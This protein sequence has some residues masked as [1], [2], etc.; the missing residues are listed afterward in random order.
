MKTTDKWIC[1]FCW[2]N[3]YKTVYESRN[4]WSTILRMHKR[5]G[6]SSPVYLCLLAM[7]DII[8]ISRLFITLSLFS[9]FWL[10]M[11]GCGIGNGQSYNIGKGKYNKLPLIYTTQSYFTIYI[12]H[13]AFF[14]LSLL[15]FDSWLVTLSDL[16]WHLI[17]L[18][19]C[20]S[21]SP[22]DLNANLVSILPIYFL[23]LISGWLQ[24]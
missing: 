24:C 7:V 11:L 19:C 18:H 6:R 4:S 2:P 14:F 1:K 22:T 12:W 9:T 17:P 20:N 13:L 16:T 8:I 21:A 23:H 10:K 15:K 3:S 5:Q